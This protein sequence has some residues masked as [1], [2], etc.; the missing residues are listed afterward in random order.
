MRVG[1][2]GGIASG[3]SAAARILASLGAVVIDHDVLARE[4]VAPASQGLHAIA[5][6]FGPEV[7]AT[8]G[9]LDRSALAS[10]IFADDAARSVLNGI[11]H[12]LVRQRAAELEAEAL[13]V[14]PGAIVVHDI[15][16]LAEAREPSD[17]DEIIVVMTPREM[18]LDRLVAGRGMTAS[19]AVARISAQASEAQRL[20]IATRVV[21]GAGTLE[22]LEA[23]LRDV[24][25]LL[26]MREG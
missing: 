7:L 1:L 8:D 3:K 18:R 24:W 4:V 2:T 13:A 26:S 22:D 20:A 17:F 23:Q 21:S 10:R 25:A 15:P 19:E 9:S 6:A 5:E 12:P 11:V 14:D 16:L